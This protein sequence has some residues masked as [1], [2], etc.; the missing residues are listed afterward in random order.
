VDTVTQGQEKSLD[1]D[2]SFREYAGPLIHRIHGF[3]AKFPPQLPRHFI[4]ALTE[5]GETVLD[6]MVGSGTVLVEA[7]L[8]GRRSVGVDIDPL[9]ILLSKV[10]TSL[11][12]S[13]AV[14]KC[15]KRIA[16]EAS[17]ALMEKVPSREAS[18]DEYL[19]NY[20][21]DV[22]RF[23]SYWFPLKS[24]AEL[25]LLVTGIGKL[26][27]EAVRDALKVAL[28][29]T[30]IAKSAGVSLGTDITHSRPH[31]VPGKKIRPAM[32]LFEKAALRTA[33]ALKE[34]EK[35]LEGQPYFPPLVLK[36]DA[37]ALP[38][39]SESVKLVVTSPPYATA[40]DY[41]RAHKFSLLWLGHKL[42]YLSWLR[43][44]YIGSEKTGSILETRSKTADEALKKLATRSLSKAQTIARYFNEMHSAI[45]EIYRGLE[46]RG[47]AVIVVGPSVVKGV[48]VLTHKALIETGLHNGFRL[49][50][51]KEREIARDCRQLPVSNN[52]NREGVEARIHEEYVVVFRK[53]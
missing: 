18:I 8:L 20:D 52:S 16:G 24:I 32:P 7:M 35:S 25:S 22:K 48:R 34:V 46:P 14:I 6:P 13:S 53:P 1:Y 40:V 51:I 47:C 27:S 2:M 12:D 39:K 38:V 28:S 31:K 42:Q 50:G 29:S 4:E 19:A 43:G 45:Q 11:C 26:E 37:K 30:I 17:V 3:A 44:R 36:G 23:F 49:L 5:P 9:A 41:M 15:A 33:D 10:K 21:A